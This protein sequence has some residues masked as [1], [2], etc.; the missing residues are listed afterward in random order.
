VPSL[1]RSAVLFY[2]LILLTEIVWM[3]IVPLAPVYARSFGLSSVETGAV[4]ASA[5]VATLVVSLPVGVLSD[6]L[7]ARTLVI[8]SSAIVTVSTLG[9]GL[10]T[11]FWTLLLAR[12]AFGAAL[13]AVWTAGLAWMAET[14]GDSGRQS[15]LG[16][17]TTVAGVGIVIGPAF[18]GLVADG[19]SVHVPFLL[20]AGLAALVTLALTRTPAEHGVHL[21]REP[22]GHTLVKA[23]REQVLLASF[24]VMAVVGL[25]GGSINLLVPLELRKDGL[26]P[27]S[28]GLAMSASSLVFVAAS[29]YV[30]RRKGALSLRFVGAAVALYGLT[31]L[32]AAADTSAPSMIAFVLVRA[33]FWASLSTLAYPLGAVG[34]VRAGVGIGAANGLLTVVWG[35]AGAA[36]PVAAGA[37]DQTAGSTWVFALLAA[38]CGVVGAGLVAGSPAGRLETPAATDPAHG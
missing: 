35:A 23:K 19:T 26:G 18:A 30:A 3:A 25:V 22:L 29:A 37:I 13:G 32:L 9:Q 31:M 14:A 16:L 38:T 21:R 7:G 33:P 10:A 20:L 6:R 2:G 34:A 24:V 11:D 28:T 4:L 12:A 1:R 5:G 8:A 17:P 27:G 15:A 36:G